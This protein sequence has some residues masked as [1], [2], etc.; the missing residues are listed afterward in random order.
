MLGVLMNRFFPQDSGGPPVMVSG[1]VHGVLAGVLSLGTMLAMLCTGLWLRHISGLHA[2]R[3]Y[4]LTSLHL[5]F[6]FGGLGAIAT[7][8]PYLGLVERVTIGAF[9]QWFFVIALKLAI[10][11]TAMERPVARAE[12][13]AG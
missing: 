3:I 10:V 8:S 7:H 6:V 9:L 12:R 5:V 11:A 13:L 4:S 1:T 2:Y